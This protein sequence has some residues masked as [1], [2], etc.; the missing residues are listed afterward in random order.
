MADSGYD[1][2][3]SVQF[4]ERVKD[5]PSF[6]NSKL[7]FLSSHPSSDERITN[8]R[9]HLPQA[10]ARLAA[11]KTDSFE[12]RPSRHQTDR[13]SAPVSR[14]KFTA[15]GKEV[16]TV[17]ESFAPVYLQPDS[18]STLLLELPSGEEVVVD[19]TERRWLKISQPVNGYM[20]GYMLAPAR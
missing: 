20:P 2:N 17:M 18:K 14:G 7:Q 13:T 10:L 11:T 16:W 9:G 1:P 6:A 19:K 5:D 3:L 15:D 12:T 4:W 8:L